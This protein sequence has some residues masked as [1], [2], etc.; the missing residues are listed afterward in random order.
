MDC[1]GLLRQDWLMASSRRQCSMIVDGMRFALLQ[2][3]WTADCGLRNRLACLRLLQMKRTS[4]SNEKDWLKMKGLL[5]KDCFERT[6]MDCYCFGLLLLWTA[7]I[8]QDCFKM[9]ALE[10]TRLQWTSTALDCYCFGLLWFGL[11]WTMPR[12]Q[13]T[14]LDCFVLLQRTEDHHD[15]LFDTVQ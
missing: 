14:A 5:R 12:L 15:G 10:R 4:A 7:L 3:Q 1:F 11:L 6:A 8:Q 9:P 13:W 2:K